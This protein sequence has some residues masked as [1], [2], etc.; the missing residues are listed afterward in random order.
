MSKLSTGNFYTFKRDTR[1]NFGNM[2]KIKCTQ[3]ADCLPKGKVEYCLVLYSSR[4]NLPGNKWMKS[5][6]PDEPDFLEENAM[7][8]REPRTGP[9]FN[10]T[11][12]PSKS[13]P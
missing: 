2:N 1:K 7:H 5:R 10:K 4:I 12:A 13:K 11:L 8:P 9:S 6:H 3:A